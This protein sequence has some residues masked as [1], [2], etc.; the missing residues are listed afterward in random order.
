MTAMVLW[1]V[2]YLLAAGVLLLHEYAS[3]TIAQFFV[4]DP[5]RE[6]L[7]LDAVHKNRYPHARGINAS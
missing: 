1:I 2:L 7:V 5:R 6:K 4:G 3:V